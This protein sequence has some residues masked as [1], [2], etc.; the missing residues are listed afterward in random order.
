MQ[1]AQQNQAYGEDK[2]EDN[3]SRAG[4]A[5]HFGTRSNTALPF[6]NCSREGNE[7][8]LFARPQDRGANKEETENIE[9]L[10]DRNSRAIA[11]EEDL[12]RKV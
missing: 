6:C 12:C 7:D 3:N 1:P 4:I 5:I 9:E 10:S 11:V 8:A 2:S